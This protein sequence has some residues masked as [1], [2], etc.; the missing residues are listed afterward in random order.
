[1]NKRNRVSEHILAI[2]MCENKK[3]NPLI[4]AFFATKEIKLPFIKKIK[5]YADEISLVLI[6]IIC[7]KEG[8]KN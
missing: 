4:T 5:N 7:K 1:M 3:K 6:G 8:K 2:I